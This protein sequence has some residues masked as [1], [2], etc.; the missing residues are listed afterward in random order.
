MDFGL[1]G[2][3]GPAPTVQLGIC[4]GTCWIPSLAWRGPAPTAPAAAAPVWIRRSRAGAALLFG[5]GA[6]LVGR[7]H[8]LPLIPG[9][10]ASSAGPLSGFVAVQ[11]G[12]HRPMKW[13]MEIER[14]PKPILSSYAAD[15][16]L[17]ER[18]DAFVIQMGERVDC[19]QDAEI[20]GDLALL[21]ELSEKF[22]AESREL[23]Y[24]PLAQAAERV[25]AAC[26][27]QSP[28]AARKSLTDLTE[29]SQRVRRGHSSSA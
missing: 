9:K 12:P 21:R 3:V 18:I 13:S 5:I 8:A 28:E 20:D 26:L 6:L 19:L 17:E 14:P 22:A 10:P 23:G 15:P 27:E 16:E 4:P 7:R 24:Q 11:F 29:I 25:V 1:A 2:T